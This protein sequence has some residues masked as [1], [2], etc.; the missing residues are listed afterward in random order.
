MGFRSVGQHPLLLRIVSRLRKRRFQILRQLLDA[1]AAPVTILDIGGTATYWE[2]VT[3]GQVGENLRITLLNTDSFPATHTNFSALA[4]DGRSM[5]RFADKQFDIVF[6][7][8]TIEHVGDFNDQMRMADEVRRVG[9]RYYVQTP[10][11][12]FPI[13]PHFIFPF[14]QFLPVWLRVDLVLRLRLGWYGSR[15]TREQVL[16]DVTGI[17]MLTR[18]EL[19]QLFPDA[20]IVDERW[21]GLVKS[22]VAYTDRPAA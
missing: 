17:R 6:S 2:L 8:S 11:R 9:R 15:P 10:N 1:A 19:R 12:Y 16:A 13:E 18:R 22:F 21:C 5:P 3:D 14:F 20:A 4:G 7:N